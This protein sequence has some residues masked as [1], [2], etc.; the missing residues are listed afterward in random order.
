MVRLALLLLLLLTTGCAIRPCLRG[1]T[2]VWSA[3]G[4]SSLGYLLLAVATGHPFVEPPQN[5]S[6]PSCVEPEPVTVAAEA[7]VVP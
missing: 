5:E 3:S 4:P 6:R 2:P 7:V 1:E